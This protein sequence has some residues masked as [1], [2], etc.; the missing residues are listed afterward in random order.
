MRADNSKYLQP[1]KPFGE[2]PEEVR[3]QMAR[4]GAIKANKTIARKKMVKEL[5]ETLMNQKPT[6]KE[7]S[8]LKNMFPSIEEGD[9]I[10]KTMLV[11]SLKQQA[12]KGN[13][14]AVELLLALLGELPAKEITGSVVTQKVFISESDKQ[15]VEKHINEV[16]AESVD[17]EE[18]K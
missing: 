4:N 15:E 16:I 17:F 10:N 13:V 8:I 1:A 11:A 7:L 5:V 18:K 14:K 12:L 9:C 6:G 3:R 2:Y